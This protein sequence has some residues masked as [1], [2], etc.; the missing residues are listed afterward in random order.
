MNYTRFSFTWG[1]YSE[2]SRREKKSDVDEG[3]ERGR[4]RE[5]A[6]TNKRKVDDEK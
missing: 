3:K 2:E 1:H 6:R 5:R 4:E